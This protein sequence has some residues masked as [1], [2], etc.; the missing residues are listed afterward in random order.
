M[1]IRD[2]IDLCAYLQVARIAAHAEGSHQELS[3]AVAQPGNEVVLDAGCADQAQ[4][5]PL[6]AAVPLR[7][8]RPVQYRPAGAGLWSAS[9]LV[10]KAAAADPDDLLPSGA[11][12]APGVTPAW[13]HECCTSGV[14]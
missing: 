5:G 1:Q 10:G 3:V 8:A 2:L 7:T 4:A 6:C 12:R 11:L 14:L 9:L 13:E